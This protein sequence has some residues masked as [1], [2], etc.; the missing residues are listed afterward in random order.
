[1]TAGAGQRNCEYTVGVLTTSQLTLDFA[2]RTWRS[3]GRTSQRIRGTDKRIDSAAWSLRSWF[4]SLTTSGNGGCRHERE[5]AS[6]PIAM[7]PLSA[8]P[9]VSKERAG[10]RRSA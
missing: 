2:K 7:R 8:R 10:H 6:V 1:M 5:G 4:E 3:K 9:E